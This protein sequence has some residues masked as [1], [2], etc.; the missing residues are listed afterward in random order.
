MPL[1]RIIAFGDSITYGYPFGNR[2]SWVELLSEKLGMKILNAGVSGD[3]LRDLQNRLL[4]DVVDQKPDY[5]LL[6]GG[7]NDVYQGS[8]LGDMEERFK[9][10][11]KTL[12]ENKITV[13]LGLP[14]P[15]AEK[16]VEERLAKFRRF[17]KKTAK[18][19]NLPTI[20]F[21]DPFFEA[22]KKRPNPS[23]LEDGVHPSAA[24]Y[25]LMA[26]VAHSALQKIFK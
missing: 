23:L 15:I 1:A 11:L 5:V 22:K 20:N 14:H 13:V 3:T 19:S 26:D 18:D 6:M 25:K 10:I 7:A 8:D 17:V 16:E 21:Y 24:G 12:K 4:I 2:Y 9:K